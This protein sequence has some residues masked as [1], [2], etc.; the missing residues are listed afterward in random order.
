MEKWYDKIKIRKLVKTAISLLVM[1]IIL[2]AVS[3]LIIDLI[4]GMQW[5]NF[6]IVDVHVLE[7][8]SSYNSNG[9]TDYVAGM[10]FAYIFGVISVISFCIVA[11]LFGIV[12]GAY[13]ERKN[14]HS[15]AV[16]V[17]APVE[18]KP[19]KSKPVVQKPTKCPNCGADI[20][21]DTVFCGN[22]GT[23]I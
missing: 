23:K 20:D 2:Y 14:S 15:Q 3:A 4:A 11:V 6:G 9:Y 18:T 10:T 8:I 5:D 1:G 7:K 12:I 16:I 13:F 17:Q 21:E 22:C 19:A